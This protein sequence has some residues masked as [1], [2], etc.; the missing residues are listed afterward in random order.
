MG[1]EDPHLPL[2]KSVDGDQIL[3]LPVVPPPEHDDRLHIM[4]VH[5]DAAAQPRQHGRHV[6]DFL[7]WEVIAADL[8]GLMELPME[9]HVLDDSAE[10]PSD[11]HRDVIPVPE[12]D[13]PVRLELLWRQ[14]LWIMAGGGEFGQLIL[15]ELLEQQGNLLLGLQQEGG[16][17]Q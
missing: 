16:S 17:N 3:R 1:G 11:S 9:M 4:D 13:L 7:L 15:L 5:N 12:A 2:R 6:L 10:D 8:H 14:Q